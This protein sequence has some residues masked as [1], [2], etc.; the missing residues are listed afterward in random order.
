MHLSPLL[1]LFLT[2]ILFLQEADKSLGALEEMLAALGLRAL[3]VPID[4]R[5]IRNTILIVQH[6]NHDPS[7]YCNLE[8]GLHN[9]EDWAYFENLRERF[10]NP[11]ILVTIHLND[12]DE[13]HLRLGP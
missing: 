12:V 7:Q 3:L 2:I 1:V 9:A 6:L 5:L 11:R 4:N 10:N 8:E 13:R